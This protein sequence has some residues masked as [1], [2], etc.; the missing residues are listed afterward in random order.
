MRTGGAM[1]FRTLVAFCL[2][3]VVSINSQDLKETLLLFGSVGYGF[4]IGGV[5]I[6]SSTTFRDTSATDSVL[7]DQ[8]DHYL[9]FGS[10]I[11]INLGAMYKVIPNLY[12]KLEL[13]FLGGVPSIT[14]EKNRISQTG[15]RST[16]T[17]KYN[18][19]RFGII[20]SAVPKFR[21]FDL[22]DAYI[23][24]GTGFY[25]NI[26]GTD[27]TGDTIAS[28]KDNNWP[29]LGLIGTFDVDYPVT[30]L[31]SLYGQVGFLAMNVTTNKRQNFNANGL[32]LAPVNFET[33]SKL[34][35]PPPKTPASSF[36]IRCGVRFGLL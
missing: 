16:S 24:V 31:L 4:G 3:C 36:T 23:G 27:K 6:D 32:E 10:G 21:M 11:A 19:S 2:L 35:S 20:V 13:E 22:L 26:S 17:T 15:G 8:K 29:S 9:N 12:G 18:H 7:V 33:D 25:F 28:T 34:L 5:G 14:V 30:D 1:K